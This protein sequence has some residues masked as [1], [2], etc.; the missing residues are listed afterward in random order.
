MFSTSSEYGSS[1]PVQEAS[2][3]PGA[4]ECWY[5]LGPGGWG[6]GGGGFPACSP[7]CPI[8]HLWPCLYEWMSASWPCLHLGSLLAGILPPSPA[9][10][11]STPTTEQPVSESKPQARAITNKSGDKCPPINLPIRPTSP[12]PGWTH[13]PHQPLSQLGSRPLC[14]SLIHAH[15]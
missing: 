9:Y 8:H 15:P 1:W 3:E 11:P 7:L 10:L 6:V 2:Q 12:H 13:D 4:K 5:P 14:L